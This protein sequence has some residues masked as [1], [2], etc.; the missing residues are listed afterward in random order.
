MSSRRGQDGGTVGRGRRL[1]L[2]AVAAVL[3]GLLVTATQLEP[4]PRGLGTHEQLGLGRCFVLAEWGVRCPSCGM[5]TAWAHIVRGNLAAA[6]QANAG[7]ALLATAT[8]V[9]VPW[10]LAAAACARRC[11]LHAGVGLVLPLFAVSVLVVSADW[12]RHTGLPLV[13]ERIPG[14]GW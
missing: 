10:L 5:T 1:V 12:L 13:W 7:G 2:L 9:A 6:W 14:G 4:H 8:V 11:Y 3:V